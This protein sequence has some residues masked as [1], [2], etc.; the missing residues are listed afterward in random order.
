MF[1]DAHLSLET[2]SR[3]GNVH[4]LVTNEF[5]HDGLRTGD[6]LERLLPLVAQQGGPLRDV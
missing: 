5:E 2:A 4:A 6:V 1:V 3:V